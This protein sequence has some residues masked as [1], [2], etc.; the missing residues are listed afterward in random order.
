MNTATHSEKLGVWAA[1]LRISAQKNSSQLFLSP[2][3]T[4]RE[5]LPG[6]DKEN[7]EYLVP[8]NLQTKINIVH[9][10]VWLL[11]YLPPQPEPC[12]RSNSAGLSTCF[13][14]SHT[15]MTALAAKGEISDCFHISTVISV[16][17]FSTFK[18]EIHKKNMNQKAHGSMF[19]KTCVHDCLLP[20]LGQLPADDG[21]WLWYQTRHTTGSRGALTHRLPSDP[22]QRPS[23]IARDLCRS[24]PARELSN[25][26]GSTV[27]SNGY[28]SRHISRPLVML[29]CRGSQMMPVCN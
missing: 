3:Q 7:K 27:F 15:F 6:T 24:R 22:R 10:V 14:V 26:W 29:T 17:Y 4:S 18:H 13:T 11:I 21:A 23:A 2:P 25:L 28:I 19:K 9:R 12:T 1:L 5:D 16:V 8:L 20:V